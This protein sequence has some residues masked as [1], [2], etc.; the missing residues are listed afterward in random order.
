MHAKSRQTLINEGC[1]MEN[2]LRLLV[3]VGAL[4]GALILLTVITEIVRAI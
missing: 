2:T 3:V 4:V 1:G